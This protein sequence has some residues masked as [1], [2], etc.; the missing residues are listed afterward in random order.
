[1]LSAVWSHGWSDFWALMPRPPGNLQAAWQASVFYDRLATVVSESDGAG[2]V[3]AG[4]LISQR[5]SGGVV[6]L[7]REK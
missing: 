5:V 7:H 2:A 1:M 6:D 4:W 3:P